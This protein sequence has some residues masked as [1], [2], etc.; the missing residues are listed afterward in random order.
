MQ[1]QHLILKSVQPFLALLLLI[2]PFCAF[3]ASETKAFNLVEVAPGVYVHLGQHVV[4]EHQQHDDIANIGFI[5][6]ERCIA[7]IDSGGSVDIGKQLRHEIRQIS[8]KPICYVINTHVHFDHI[9]GNLAF[10]KEQPIF[11]GH[12]QLAERIEQ[13]RSFFLTQ[14]KNDLGKNPDTNSII[15][16]DELVADMK[17]IDLGNRLLT[18]TAYPVAHSHTDLT[19][20]D[21]QTKTLWTGDLIFRKRVPV[22]TGSLLGWLATIKKLQ[23]LAVKKVIPGHG[24]VANSMTEAIGKQQKY[25]ERLLT[26]TRRAIA[27]GTF[28]NEAMETIDSEN[29]S[30]WLLYKSQHRAN[31]SKAFIELEWE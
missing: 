16:P 31:V 26:K 1:Y 30:A 19:V 8:Q 15:A 17:Q 18:L 2:A 3:C 6:G 7:V 5:I 22:L 12:Q 10:K 14:F 13:S 23:S 27:S 28:I 4:I 9:L 25:L 11:I 29:Q 21:H 24:D 20:F